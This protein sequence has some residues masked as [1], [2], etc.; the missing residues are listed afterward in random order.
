MD[1]RELL[2]TREYKRQDGSTFTAKFYRKHSRKGWRVR[3]SARF[4]YGELEVYYIPPYPYEKLDAFVYK[5]VENNPNKNM[6]EPYYKEGE[7]FYV[8]GEKKTITYD[9]FYKDNPKYFYLSKSVKDPVNIYKKRALEYFR[10]RAMELGKRMG[11]DMSD[12]AIHVGLFLSFYGDCYPKKHVMKF[13]FRLFAYLPSLSDAIVY[14]E[15]A[16]IFEIRHNKRFYSI[17]EMYY[18]DYEQCEED[19]RNSLFEGSK[20]RFLI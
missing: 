7:Y 17:V 19:I 13:D 10:K 5:V 16:H 18:P 8:L 15:L 20:K 9:S 12:W 4:S 14:H 3:A 2:F 6:T 11:V 1:K